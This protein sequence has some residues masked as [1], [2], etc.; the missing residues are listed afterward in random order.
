MLILS[1]ASC[2][3]VFLAMCCYSHV[4]T[5]YLKLQC[6]A[7]RPPLVVTSNNRHDV[8]DFDRVIVGE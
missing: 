2:I 7:V 6:P 4:N 5:L 1:S 8:V 3:H